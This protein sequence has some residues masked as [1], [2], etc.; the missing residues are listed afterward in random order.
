[1]KKLIIF[2]MDGVLIDVSSSYR[3][4]VRKTASIFLLPCI[5]SELLP[6]PLFSLTDLAFLKGTGSLNNDWDLT[7]K[8]ITMMFSKISGKRESLN[9][10]EWD[11]K[12]LA[13]FLKSEEKPIEKLFKEAG[14]LK[15]KEVDFFYKGDVG[16]GNIIKQIFQEVYLGKQLFSETYGFRAQ[17]YLEEALILKEKL[18]IERDV[19]SYLAAFHKLAIATGR[20]AAEALYPIRENNINFFEKI[21]TLDDCIAAENE[22]EKNKGEKISLGKPHPFMLDAIASY[23]E[24]RGALSEKLYYIGDMPDDMIAAKRSKYRFCAIGV[25][26]SSP[27]KTNSLS[28]LKEAGADYIANTPQELIELLK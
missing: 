21:L 11:V 12:E 18:L 20:P 13:C 24:S 28:R 2:D 27:N 25:T 26:Y 23:Y 22:A 16:S 15:F 5:N 14:T 7:H 6:Q 19:L 17:H 10:E 9:R 1:M 4:C 3:E 8:V